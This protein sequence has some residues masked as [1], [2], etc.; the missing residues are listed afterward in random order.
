MFWEINWEFFNDIFHISH[1]SWGQFIFS[2]SDSLF[3]IFF[4]WVLYFISSK[5]DVLIFQYPGP[6]LFLFGIKPIFIAKWSLFLFWFTCGQFLSIDESMESKKF[7]K[8]KM[9]F[10][11][12]LDVYC[13]LHHVN[14]DFT[15]NT[16]VFFIEYCLH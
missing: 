8:L 9:K 13:P 14:P 1:R 12:L 2:R 6:L 5:C 16:R 4:K 10:L 3:Y 7:S 15:C 11:R